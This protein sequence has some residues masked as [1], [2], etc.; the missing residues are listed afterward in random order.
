MLGEV[1][2]LQLWNHWQ[3]YWQNSDKHSE[4]KK[5][6]RKD[7]TKAKLQEAYQTDGKILTWHIFKMLS[8]WW[9]NLLI[10]PVSF[11]EA[12]PTWIHF[13]TGQ[14][15]DKLLESDHS[16]IKWNNFF[17]QFKIISDNGLIMDWS[18]RWKFFAA[19]ICWWL[20]SSLQ[21]TINPRPVLCMLLPSQGSP[22]D[23]SVLSE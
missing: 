18:Q 22:N 16:R 17:L 19:T 7:W 9:T 5:W 20:M 23:F 10:I 1:P 2:K 21:S 4:G 15:V 12:V 6:Y 14:K 8:H 3:N 13:V 11:S